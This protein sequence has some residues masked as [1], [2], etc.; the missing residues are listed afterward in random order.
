MPWCPQSQNLP[1]GRNDT[2]LVE[3]G[4]SPQLAV[5]GEGVK[6]RLERE[7]MLRLR[8]AEQFMAA[9]RDLVRLKPQ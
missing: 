7:K 3:D 2:V 8:E 1:L 4:K 6:E 9:R 5:D